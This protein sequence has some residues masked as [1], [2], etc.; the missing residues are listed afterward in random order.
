VLTAISV[1]DPTYVPA[2]LNLAG[3]AKK[4]GKSDE[5]LAWLR[6]ASAMAPGSTVVSNYAKAIGLG[7]VM[8]FGTA[9]VGTPPT[10]AAPAAGASSDRASAPEQV[11][12]AGD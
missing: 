6:R 5:T 2:L 8:G 7:E 9:I 1:K 3:L 4:A 12:W 10:G 11:G